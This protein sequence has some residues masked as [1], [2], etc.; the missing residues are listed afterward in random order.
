MKINVTQ[1]WCKK[2]ADMEAFAEVG[3]GLLAVDPVLDDGDPVSNNLEKFGDETRFALQRFVELGRRS[4]NLTVEKLAERADIDLSELITL[5]KDV[6][7]LPETRTLYQLAQVFNVSQSKL[8]ELS[9]LTQPKEVH[10]L[11]EAVRYAARSESIEK[12]TA[13]EQA[14]LDGLISVLSEK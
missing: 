11:E 2:M 3:A 13:E 12:L 10:Y 9:G 5:E 6:H 7:H 4:M 1:A 14:A 8:M